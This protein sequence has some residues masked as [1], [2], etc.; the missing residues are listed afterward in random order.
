MEAIEPR[1][2]PAL[3]NKYLK[4]R[5][6]G[7]VEHVDFRILKIIGSGNAKSPLLEAYAAAL[8]INKVKEPY[9][10]ILY[11]KGRK[12]TRREIFNIC[13]EITEFSLNRDGGKQVWVGI[14]PEALKSL[15]ILNSRDWNFPQTNANS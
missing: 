12:T 3:L 1:R 5:Q 7:P 2:T 14:L 6:A 4:N 9:D 10:N 8:T 13:T 11:G 15:L